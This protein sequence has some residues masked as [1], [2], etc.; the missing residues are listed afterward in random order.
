[1]IS[2]TRTDRLT[3]GE[4]AK[5]A[6]VRAA[7]YGWAVFPLAPGLKRPA[8]ANWEQ[9]ATDRVEY[10]G[11]RWPNRCTGFGIA[12]GPSGLYVVDCDMPKDDTPPPS[13]EAA[14]AANGFEMLVLLAAEQ[15][16]PTPGNTFTTRTGRGGTHLYYRM[17][18]DHQLGNTASALGWLIDT[19]GRGGYVVGPGSTV[20]GKTYEVID[21]SPPAELP[22]WILRRLLDRQKT[23]SQ[24]G[25]DPRASPSAVR[26]SGAAVGPQWAAAALAGELSKLAG[27]Q[28]ADN[29]RNHLLNTVAY[30]LGR[31]VGGGVLDRARV[32]SELFAATRSW[33][34]VG[35]PPFT[36]REA[37]ATVRSG[38]AA[39][40]RNPR[41]PVPRESRHRAA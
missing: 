4:R 35:E 2:N 26:L 11:E 31:L 1:V 17:P 25:A 15:G 13:P 14:D 12:C 18:A 34:G 20:D 24:G 39:G 7:R 16:E 23:A 22:A 5:R 41:T 21:D 40:E 32:A 33:W 37:A 9:R 8:V 10:V 30:T 27:H 36:A 28:G 3:P 38:L 6:A 29:G 19:R